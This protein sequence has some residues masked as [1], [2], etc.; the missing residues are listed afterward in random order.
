MSEQKYM[1]LTPNVRE[2]LASVMQPEEGIK[3]T[4]GTQGRV[5][6]NESSIGTPQDR[7][8]PS[9]IEL[10]ESL[11]NSEDLKRGPI[12]LTDS[13]NPR[14]PQVEITAVSKDESG[15]PVVRTLLRQE[16]DLTVSVHPSDLEIVRPVVE[17]DHKSEPIGATELP[18]RQPA[19]YRLSLEMGSQQLGAEPIFTNTARVF[20]RSVG[21]LPESNTKALWQRVAADFAAI[22]EQR[23]QL[24]TSAKQLSNTVAEVPGAIRADI[25]SLINQGRQSLEGIKSTI[26]DRIQQSSSE[27]VKSSLVMGASKLAETG[28]KGLGLASS[29]LQNRA[30]KVKDYG[31]ARSALAIYQKGYE[32]TG[33]SHFQVSGYTVEAIT[34]GYA[35]RDS[36]DR[37]I[38]SFGTDSQGSPVSVTKTSAATLSDHKALNQLSKTSIIQGSQNGEKAYEARLQS[39]VTEIREVLQGHD[40]IKGQ[41]YYVSVGDQGGRSLTIR[42]IAFPRRELKIDSTGKLEHSNLTLADFNSLEKTMD[43]ASQAVTAAIESASKEQSRQ[44][45]EV[46][47]G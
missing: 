23:K 26:R 46:T 27:D 29:Y 39:V 28:S 32:R 36:K 40:P 25:K 12:Q 15:K 38:M 18:D 4:Y 14:A 35:V 21:T 45:A 24:A 34:N 1:Q 8:E 41:N 22:N 33:E 19:P 16:R 2:A 42:T 10:I 20:E 17:A 13:G 31:M 47:I 7:L 37:I 30:E 11:L 9:Q 6:L 3:I 43:K 5:V 44:R